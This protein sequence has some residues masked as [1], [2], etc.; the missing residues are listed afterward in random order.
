MLLLRDL[1]C[2]ACTCSV[3][4]ATDWQK[5]VSK[6]KL[7]NSTYKTSIIHTCLQLVCCSLVWFVSVTVVIYHTDFNCYE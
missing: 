1:H 5:F 3:L 7:H 2:V 4:S 6:K